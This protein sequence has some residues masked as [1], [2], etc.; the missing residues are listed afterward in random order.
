MR[1]ELTLQVV[2]TP[3]RGPRVTYLLSIMHLAISIA[4]LAVFAAA[5]YADLF[6]AGSVRELMQSCRRTRMLRSLGVQFETS[7]CTA[8]TGALTPGWSWQGVW[9]PEGLVHRHVELPNGVVLHVAELRPAEETYSLLPPVLLLHGF[10]EISYTWVHQMLPVASLAKRRVIVPDLRGYGETIVPAD[11]AAAPSS[12]DVGNVTTDLALFLEIEN[13]PRAVVIGH[14]WGAMVSW[15]FAS[16]YPERT[17]AIG[18]IGVPHDP[19]S[20]LGTWGADW[21]ATHRG[22]AYQMG[23]LAR[24]KKYND[25]RQF[26]YMVAFDEGSVETLFDLAPRG[27]FGMIYQSSSA[28]SFTKYANLALDDLFHLGLVDRELLPEDLHDVLVRGAV[29]RGFAPQIAYYRSID[30]SWAQVRDAEGEESTPTLEGELLTTFE[31]PALLITCGADDVVTPALSKGME[32]RCSEMTRVHE[33][34]F[35]HWNAH[36]HPQK[37]ANHIVAWLRAIE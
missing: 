10:P 12:Y 4:T 7:G 20:L 23:P 35:T 24:L 5:L 37:T 6:A 28:S 8:A 29:M 25:M 26:D 1:V 19:F 31:K 32:S 15:A 14:D 17:T 21:N 30:R 3:L 36:Q 22:E 9:A 27:A 11:V 18:A 34:D 13:I 16:L 2:G 33:P